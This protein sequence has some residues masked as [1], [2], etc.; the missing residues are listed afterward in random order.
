MKVVLLKYSDKNNDPFYHDGHLEFHYYFAMM[1]S[2]WYNKVEINIFEGV[3][4]PSYLN[5][6]PNKEDDWK[7]YAEKI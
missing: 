6:D 2:S 4:D 1:L 3:Y 5:L 7:I